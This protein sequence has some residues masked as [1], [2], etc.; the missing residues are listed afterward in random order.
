MT[1]NPLRGF[2]PHAGNPRQAREASDLAAARAAE[3]G[4]APGMLVGTGVACVT[5]DYGAGAD[6]SLGRVELSPDGRITIYCDLPR[7]ATASAPRSRTG[8]RPIWRRRR[9]SLVARVDTYDALG[10]VSS[11][12]PYTWTRR[13]RTLR[14]NPR[15]VPAISSATSASATAVRTHSAA[16]AARVIFR[17]GLWPAALELWRIA[18]NDPRAKD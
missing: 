7:W 2:G 4:R 13:R 14:R 16:E 6:C 17:F 5:K 11:G 12:D 10:L 8:W 18:P 15:W 3:I 9:R 1:G